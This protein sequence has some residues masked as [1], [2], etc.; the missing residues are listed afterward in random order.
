M[1]KALAF[2]KANLYCREDRIAFGSPLVGVDKQEANSLR[3][4]WPFSC[5]LLRASTQ[6]AQ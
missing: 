2:A 1:E 5:A 4:Y 3:S 6:I